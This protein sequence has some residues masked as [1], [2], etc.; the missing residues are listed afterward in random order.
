MFKLGIIGSENSHSHSLAH[1]VNH[2]KKVPLRVTHLWG[3][4][5]TSAKETAIKGHIPN[6]TANW[7]DMLGNVDAVM[8]DHRH[9][10]DHYEPARF[11]IENHVPTFVDKPFTTDLEQAR[12]LLKLA[13]RKHTPL[14]S[15]GF[16]PL[17]QT[18]QAYKKSIAGKQI[19]EFESS[20]HAS[21]DDPHGGIFFYGFHQVDALIE[22]LG[23]EIE[24]VKLEK[25]AEGA[26]ASILYRQGI[27]ARL[28]FIAAD[29]DFQWHIVTPQSAHSLKR[30]YDDDSYLP[31]ATAI[32]D[33]LCTKRS[34]FNSERMLAPIALLEA[35]QSSFTRG[36]FASPELSF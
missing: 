32:H 9:G 5:E 14:T 35:L 18:F 30:W 22:I 20:G 33:F 25:T 23:S 15:F 21:I 13:R 27:S 2:Q 31:F 6:I 17:Q 29:C 16:I 36:T 3:E 19:L 34:D 26:S 4:T 28:R 11:F 7:R 1:L 12:E 24:T 10:A 8:I